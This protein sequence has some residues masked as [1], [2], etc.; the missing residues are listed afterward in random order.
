M[1]KKLKV[2]STVYARV[3]EQLKSRLDDYAYENG[4]SL[5]QAVSELINEGLITV[6]SIG[7]ITQVMTRK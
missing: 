7:H 3:P 5:S 4:L 1:G 6:K 2:T